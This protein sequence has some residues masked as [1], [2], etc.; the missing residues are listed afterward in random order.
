MFLPQVVKSARVMKKSVA[1]LIP[2]I[3]QELK[4][5]Q[6]QSA[7]KILLATVKGDVHDIG[8]NIVGVVL[9]CNNFE[10]IDLGVMVPAERI[11]EEARIHNPDIIGLSGLI[12]PSLDEMVHVAKELERNGFKQPLLIGGAT[13]SRIHTAVKIAQN[14]SQPVIHV[15]DASKSVP[16]VSNL[17]NI[18]S[19]DE[20]AQNIKTE[21][22]KLRENHLKSHGNS[23]LASYSDSVQSR[24]QINWEDEIILQPKHLGI[25]S[26]TNY[27]LKE[28]RK[29]INWTQFFITWEIKGRYPQIFDNPEKGTEAKKL[30]DDANAMLDEIIGN[31]LIQANYSYGI[32]PA[33]SINNQD[34]VVYSDT[35]KNTILTTFNFLR[36]QHQIKQ[37]NPNLSLVDYIAPK[38]SGLTDYIGFFIVTA[39]IG[40]EE[41]SEIYLK[42]HDDYKSFMIK[43]LAD[44]LAEAFAELLHEKVRKEYWGYA[45]KEELIVDDL[46][47]EN[48]QGIRPA[49][50]YPSIPDHSEITKIMDLIGDDNT[51]LNIGITENY[52]MTPAASV[53][54]LYFANKAAR[55]FAVGKI[56][57]EQM[58]SYLDRKGSNR[59]VIE[60]LLNHYLAD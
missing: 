52:M 16:V 15:L 24:F 42:N 8:K 36:Q 2:Y 50:G 6:K 49:I 58:E 10:I 45:A 18:N 40:V 60:K 56:K 12:T 44:R 11:L 43:I 29:Y 31:N 28:I 48:Y 9:A 53:S 22:D 59:P 46:L 54:G 1:Y 13:T 20:F 17:L 34:V 38:E 14:Y 23:N 33:N 41:L 3:E 32:L 4:K 55:Y 7:G 19:K 51:I 26:G 37:N 39:G 27:D 47:S 35:N 57:K 30:F 21:Y 5:G 25:F